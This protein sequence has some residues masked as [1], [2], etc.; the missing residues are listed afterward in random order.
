MVVAVYYECTTK[1]M[2]RVQA[3]Q[4]RTL[5][6]S[7][8]KGIRLAL[9]CGENKPEGDAWIGIDMR[10]LKGVDIVHDLETY[11]WPLPDE[12]ARLVTAGCVLPHINPARMGIFRF[13]DEVWRVLKP[14]RSFM[15]SAAYAGSEFY[16]QDP[17]HCCGLTETSFLY[18][19]PVHQSGLYKVYR[20]KPWKIK[21]CTFH[22]K[23]LIEVELEKRIMD[24]SYAK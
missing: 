1:D 14:G 19:D 18:F 23:G 21:Q 12:C 10:P 20:P 22:T 3:V 5:L 2:T 16:W 17:S 24:S 11:P 4:K 6:T 9:G 7:Y 15:A 13:M 8:P